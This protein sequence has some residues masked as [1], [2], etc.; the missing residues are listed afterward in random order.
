MAGM[1]FSLMQSHDL[2]T[3]V[4]GESEIDGV[5]VVAGGKIG[6][7][8]T[9]V[10]DSIDQPSEVIGFADGTGRIRYKPSNQDEIKRLESV[11]RAIEENPA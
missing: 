8:G 2:V 6:S 3:R 5:K 1:L 7:P 10:V 9:I 11:K 4:M